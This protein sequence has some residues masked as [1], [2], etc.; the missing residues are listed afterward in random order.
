MSPEYRIYAENYVMLNEIY[1]VE[2]LFSMQIQ[3]MQKLYLLKLFN[4]KWIKLIMCGLYQNRLVLDICF[5]ESHKHQHYHSIG[6]NNCEQAR[7]YFVVETE[8]I[9]RK[10]NDQGQCCNINKCTLDNVHHC[11]HYKTSNSM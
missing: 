4:K 7:W 9:G 5:Y 2:S 1:I 8:T 11:K 6:I 3:R 10:C